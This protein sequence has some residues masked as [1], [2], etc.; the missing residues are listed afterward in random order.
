MSWLC[1][2][3]A[4]LAQ[5]QVPCALIQD[6]RLLREPWLRRAAEGEALGPGLPRREVVEAEAVRST[7]TG[8]R[9][10]LRGSAVPRYCNGDPR[11]SASLMQTLHRGSAPPRRRRSAAREGEVTPP[12]P[13]RH[14]HLRRSL[15]WSQRNG[16]RATSLMQSDA[17]MSTQACRLGLCWKLGILTPLTVWQFLIPTPIFS[18]AVSWASSRPCTQLMSTAWK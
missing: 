13:A 11:R 15:L 4:I 14:D 8:A 9:A 1:K 3:I 2:V 10:L 18:G 7:V 6:L 12:N 5:H 16:S 17:K